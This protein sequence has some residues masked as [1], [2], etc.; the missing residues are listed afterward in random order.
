M[1]LVPSSSL[2]CIERDQEAPCG[3]VSLTE[4]EEN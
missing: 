1:D 2:L 3:D 4:M